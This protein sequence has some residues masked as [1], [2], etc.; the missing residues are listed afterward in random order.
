MT[1]SNKLNDQTTS[2]SPTKNIETRIPLNLYLT[3]VCSTN[4][5][6][7]QIRRRTS[8]DVFLR[9]KHRSL[10]KHPCRIQV[11][12]WP[13]RF[14]ARF[15]SKAAWPA[16]RPRAAL[17]LARAAAQAIKLLRSPRD[18][19]WHFNVYRTD[20]SWKK[21]VCAPFVSWTLVYF[22]LFMFIVVFLNRSALTW[23]S[24]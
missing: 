11:I 4:R 13:L 21:I 6:Y 22:V 20:S 9:C 17:W 2:Q 8:P 7:N 23:K 18:L 10:D 1:P 14:V 15:T 24:S 5:K 16:L 12:T 19:T 3:N